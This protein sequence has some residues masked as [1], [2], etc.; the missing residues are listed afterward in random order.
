MCHAAKTKPVVRDRFR[1]SSPRWPRFNS[2]SGCWTS[3]RFARLDSP[4]HARSGDFFLLCNGGLAEAR[5][6]ENVR[7]HLK[8]HPGSLTDWVCD[9]SFIIKLKP[10]RYFRCRSSKR[11]SLH[12]SASSKFDPCWG[13]GP[14]CRGVADVSQTTSS[15]NLGTERTLSK[16]RPAPRVHCQ[17]WRRC[18]YPAGSWLGPLRRGGELCKTKGCSS[19]AQSLYPSNNNSLW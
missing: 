15:G 14:A 2:L 11:S 5:S 17:V 4:D 1:L 12:W 8:Q 6:A 19:R 16:V 3:S 9:V 18:C 7:R 10:I 13:S